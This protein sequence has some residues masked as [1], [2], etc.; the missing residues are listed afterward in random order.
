MSP[1]GPRIRM[2]PTF[3]VAGFLIG[4]WLESVARIRI[5]TGDAASRMLALVGTAVALL[6]FFFSLSGILAFGRAD[7]PM[8]PFKPA[9]ALVQTGPYRFTRNPMYVGA[10]ITYVGVAIAMNVVWPI[11]LV[12]LV[13]AGLYRFVIRVEE[14]YLHE[15]FGSEYDAYRVHVR[16]WI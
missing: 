4:L 7:T 6:G 14:R 9:R 16:R 1:S 15:L 8:F 3:F 11:I 12:P 5:V 2:P 10:I 13:L